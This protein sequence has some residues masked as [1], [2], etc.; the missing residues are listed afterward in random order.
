[1]TGYDAERRGYTSD[2]DDDTYPYAMWDT[3][4]ISLFG[5]GSPDIYATTLREAF[6][7]CCL[8]I[9][10]GVGERFEIGCPGGTIIQIDARSYA[11]NELEGD[12]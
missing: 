12:E 1:M 3:T 8:Q 4:S 6:E 9:A 11:D 5:G 10:D 2:E 7:W